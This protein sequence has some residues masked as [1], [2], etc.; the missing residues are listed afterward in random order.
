MSKRSSKKKWQSKPPA[1]ESSKEPGGQDRAKTE[2]HRRAPEKPV[3]GNKDRKGHLR[4]LLGH[5]RRGR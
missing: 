5:R 3:T 4:N 2:A 1:K